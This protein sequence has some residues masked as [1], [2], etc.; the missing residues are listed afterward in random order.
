M[1]VDTAK[2]AARI[3]LTISESLEKKN[4][5][6]ALIIASLPIQPNKNL[7]RVGKK[8]NIKADMIKNTMIAETYAG[9]VFSLS[10]HQ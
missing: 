6:T 9:N 4:E 5:E 3:V 10:R 2:N 7:N 1:N 8:L